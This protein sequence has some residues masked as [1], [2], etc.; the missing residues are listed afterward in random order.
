MTGKEL[1]IAIGLAIAGLVIGYVSKR[2]F[3]SFN[4]FVHESDQP[5]VD[6]D[7]CLERLKEFFLTK[8]SLVLAEEEYEDL[9]LMGFSPIDSFE[10]TISKRSII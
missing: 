6:T 10:I 1:K 3:D 5:N 2:S 8:D 9:L 7:Q 4:Q